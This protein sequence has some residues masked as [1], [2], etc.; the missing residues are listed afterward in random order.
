MP[1]FVARSPMPVPAADLFAWH[2][3][4]G[5]FERLMPPWEQLRIIRRA[6]GIQDGA[7][8]T[9]AAKKGP[10]WLPWEARHTGYIEGSQFCDEQVKGPMAF[11]RHTHRCLPGD[12]PNTSIL[13]DLVEYRL[14]GGRV[15]QAL[16]NAHMQALLARMF[17]FRHERTRLDLA[18]HAGVPR[19]R[20]VMTGASGAIGGALL[21]FLT[22][23]GHRVQRLVRRKADEA[24][25]EIFWQP[26]AG[27]RGGQIDDAALEGVD[28]VIHLAGESVAKGRW[29]AAKK[30]AIRAS[31]VEGTRLLAR[32]LANLRHKP[33][34]LIVASGIHYYGD[35]GDQELTEEAGIGSGFLAEV[36]REWEA[37]DEP[38][39]QAGIRVVNLRVG[40]VLSAKAG[41]LKAGLRPARLGLASILGRGSQWWSWIGQDDLLGAI[42]HTLTTES[43]RGGV[44]AVTPS[45]VPMHEF[46]S[47]IAAHVGRPLFARFPG[48]LLHAAL[49]EKVDP[50]LAS[51]RAVPDALRRSGFRFTHPLLPDALAWELGS[52]PRPPTGDL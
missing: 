45:P 38:A 3:R 17:T 30:E 21:H 37:A 42:L 28:A 2:A 50:L 44:N 16:G 27:L 11:W 5:A 35:R 14:P 6:G 43:I 32:A 7:T 12:T 29:T 41:M 19:M 10:L 36:S 9:F 22:T 48:W 26:G 31:R 13:E 4:P 23:G 49:G 8:L 34:C 46:A 39:R 1:E 40:V 47:A 25:G 52:P 51:T 18:R 33:R 24:A 15:G 20:I